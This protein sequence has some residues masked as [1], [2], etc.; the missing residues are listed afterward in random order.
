[1]KWL[2][3]LFTCLFSVCCWTNVNA[4]VVV[5]PVFDR[6]DSYHFR[7]DKVYLASDTTY[8]YCSCKDK[9]NSSWINISKDTYLEDVSSGIRYPLLK[10]SGLPYSPEKM[11]YTDSINAQVTLYFPH[12]D[13]KRFDIIEN[14]DSKAFNIYGI[15]LNSTFDTPYTSEDIAKYFNLSM[16]E[17]KNNNWQSAISYDLKQLESANFVCGVRSFPSACAMYNLAMDYFEANELEKVIEWGEKSIN[18]L[19]ALPQDSASLDGLARNYNNLSNV[20]CLLNQQ[21]KEMQY[22]ELSLAA[23][24]MGDGI[25]AIRYEKYLQDMAKFYYHEGNYPKA[26]LYG[27]EVVDIYK[28]KYEENSEYG[29]VYVNALN[30]LC[31]FC[32]RMDKFQ[33]AE[34]YGRQALCLVDNVI[35]QDSLTWL[36]LKYTIYNN[37]AGALS[38]TGKSDEAIGYLEKIIHDTNENQLDNDV[39]YYTSRMQ[40]A[41]FLFEQKQDTAMVLNEYESLLKSLSDSIESNKLYY[42]HYIRMLAKLYRITRYRNPD[43]GMQ[44]LNRL[45]QVQKEREGEMSVAYGS[46]CLDYVLNI[47]NLNRALDGDKNA[48]DSLVFYLRQSSEI[49]KRHVNNSTY[50]MS[51]IERNAYWKRFESVYNWLIPTICGMTGTNVTNSMAYDAALFYKGWLLSSETEVKDVILS[52]ND[53]A[54]VRLY[55]KYVENLSLLEEQY[56]SMSFITNTDSLKSIIREQEYFLSQKVT[57]FNRQ[58][59]GTNYSWGDVKKNLGSEDI[60]IEVT[61]YFSVDGSEVF[62]DAYIIDSNS[63]APTIIFLFDEKQLSDCIVKDSID[64]AGLYKLIWG[65]KYL[66]DAIKDKKNIYFSASGLLN[67]LGIEYLPIADGQYIC[68]KYNIYRLSSTRE[69]CYANNPIK[70]ER[71]CLFGGLDYNNEAKISIDDNSK[72]TYRV[73]RTVEDSIVK[74]GGFDPLFGSK[75]EIAQINNEMVKR[76][77]DCSVYTD[78]NGTEESFINLSGSPINIIHLSTHGMYVPDEGDS[79][80]KK[81]NFRF[82]ISDE[83]PDVDEETQ[84]LSRSFLVMSGGNM[85][86]RRDSIPNG[87]EDGILTA[88]EISHLDFENLDLVVLSAC[89]TALGTID[90]EGVYGLQRA[91]KKAGANTILM[92]LDKVDDE[93]TQILMVE[94]YKNLMAGKSKHQSLKDAQKYLRQVENGKYDKPEYWASFIMLDGLN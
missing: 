55:K 17:G 71:V 91:F 52:S 93:A 76:N 25:G 65:N 9:G 42:P 47:G 84:S 8:I 3:S 61:T 80:S 35:C 24:R 50:N 90:T 34:V 7:V 67:S 14:E 75:Q 29:C 38:C 15:N 6:T 48:K 19:K 41:D 74:R 28:T 54:L 49:F 26:L 39:V 89:Q 62:Y 43:H 30:N 36:W 60:A 66:N 37:L 20:Y 92:S 58:Y 51:R 4:Q 33:E 10:A 40:Y 94:F 88:L 45:I 2:S 11:Y 70:T 57:R 68:D 18:L 59:K 13:T 86:I 87:K 63:I 23:R 85:L 32:Q 12:I 56:N 22:M 83:T 46:V 73:S 21:E 31:E 64:Y 5:N 69:L 79:I 81:N 16:Q 53:D 44:Y 27:K 72:Q 77:V 1:M 78:L 82:I